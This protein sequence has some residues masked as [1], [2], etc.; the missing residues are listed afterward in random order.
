MA[1]KALVI[2]AYAGVDALIEG[3]VAGGKRRTCRV[4]EKTPRRSGRRISLSCL[5]SEMRFRTP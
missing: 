5:Q 4:P 2:Y 3:E 1:N